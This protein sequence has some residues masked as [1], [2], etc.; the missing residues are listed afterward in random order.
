MAEYLKVKQETYLLDQT[1]YLYSINSYLTSALF[2]ILTAI[3][4]NT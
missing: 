3:I 1:I 2:K 4:Q